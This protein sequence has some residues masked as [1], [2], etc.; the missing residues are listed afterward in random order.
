MLDVRGEVT[1]V[2][3]DASVTVSG[4]GPVLVVQ[5]DGRLPADRRLLREASRHLGASGLDAQIV[6]SGGRRLATVGASV[7]S[8]LGR[9]LAG[10]PAI[11][12]TA[13]GI[14]AAIRK[15]TTKGTNRA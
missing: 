14:A 2:S 6:D 15:H 5:I 12:P 13:R 4:E 11:R 9:L 7:R 8:P 1:A 10:S 3:G